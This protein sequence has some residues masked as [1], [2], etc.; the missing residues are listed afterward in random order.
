MSPSTFHIKTIEETHMLAAEIA[1]TS[2]PGDIITLTG[3]LGAGKTEFARGFIQS[4]LGK[5]CKVTS[6]TFI[7]IQEY[8]G[9]HYPIFHLDLYRIE[10]PDELDQLGLEDLTHGVCLVEWPERVR[11]MMMSTLDI[12]FQIEANGMRKI[13][14]ESHNKN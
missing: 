7:I 11:K 3:D 8:E 6:P 10:H 1:A 4:V 2:K 9:P 12:T 13:R 14:V 5:S